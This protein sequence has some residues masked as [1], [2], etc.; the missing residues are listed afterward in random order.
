MSIG[1]PADLFRT[2]FMARR[3]VEILLADAAALT[4]LLALGGIAASQ[5]RRLAEDRRAI[6]I[7][8][9]LGASGWALALRYLDGLLV[10]FALA[11]LLPCAA[12]VAVSIVFPVATAGLTAMLATPLIVPVLAIVAAVSSAIVVLAVQWRA[13]T[14]SPAALMRAD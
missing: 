1:T 12:L 6:G 9:A 7:G 11:A 3:S 5:A 2:Q 4:L 8:I 14:T 13:R 10:D